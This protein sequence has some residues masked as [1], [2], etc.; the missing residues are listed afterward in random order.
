MKILKLYRLA[1]Y[2]G[3]RM[4]WERKFGHPFEWSEWLV[5]YEETWNQIKSKTPKGEPMNQAEQA[6]T[7]WKGSNR[8]IT[9]VAESLGG[10]EAL[11]DD[12]YTV[13]E[14]E[15]GS[16]VVDSACSESTHNSVEDYLKTLE[17]FESQEYI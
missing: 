3:F 4:R 8:S 5:A 7:Q 16:C 15:D 6:Y 1:N 14:M 13:I 17:E 12:L 2:Y 10:V 11:S 9:D